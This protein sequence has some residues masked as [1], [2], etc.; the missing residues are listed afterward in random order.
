[1]ITIRQKGKH[2]VADIVPTPSD[3]DAKV[4][5]VCKLTSKGYISAEFTSVD[6]RNTPLHIAC[7]THYPEKFILDHLM[8]PDRKLDNSLPAVFTENSSGELPLHYAVMDRKGVARV[9]FE[10]LLERIWSFK[11][12]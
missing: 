10:A 1:M 6:P 11:N 12:R 3:S 4:M 7:L 8:K 2:R 9:I 5:R